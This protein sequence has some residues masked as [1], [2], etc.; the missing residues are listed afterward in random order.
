MYSDILEPEVR[1]PPDERGT[2]LVRPDG[3]VAAVTA[4][5]DL[6]MLDDYLIG[7]V[8]GGKSPII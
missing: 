3:Y 6:G 7:L 2:W 5:E 4:A 8:Q 1:T